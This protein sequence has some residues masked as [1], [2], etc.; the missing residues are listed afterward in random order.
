MLRVL[1]GLP[2]EVLIDSTY[3]KAHRSAAEKGA[4]SRQ[5]GQ[6]TRP[7]QASCWHCGQF[8]V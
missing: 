7:G 1:A 3:V 4:H 2:A 5:S 8:K 6:S